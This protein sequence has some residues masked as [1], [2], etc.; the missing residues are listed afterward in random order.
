MDI[1]IYTRIQYICIYTYKYIF[2]SSLRT[3]SFSFIFKTGMW[4]PPSVSANHRPT[5]G[6]FCG[7]PARGAHAP[8]TA[9]LPRDSL[10]PTAFP[11]AISPSSGHLF[12]CFHL[13]SL[14]LFLLYAWVRATPS[15]TSPSPFPISFLFSDERTP[16]SLKRRWWTVF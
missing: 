3:F 4:A 6:T 15:H 5:C 16:V 10:S 2:L 8:A 13:H 11:A 1:Y 9:L 7:W 14:H 12:T